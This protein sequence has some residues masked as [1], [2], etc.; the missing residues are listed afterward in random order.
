M[1]FPAWQQ[2]W[3][4]LPGHALRTCS[5]SASLT[6]QIFR[7]QTFFYPGAQAELA[8]AFF[9]RLKANGHIVVVITSYQ[10]FPGRID[11]PYD[12]RHTTPQ[13]RVIHEAVDGYLHCFRCLDL[14]AENL[15]P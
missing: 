12:D 14:A 10:E 8:R 1:A 2:Q 5:V 6:L 9:W 13:D 7:T 15:K 3:P 11:N 4:E